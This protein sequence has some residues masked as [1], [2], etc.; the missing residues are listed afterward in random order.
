MSILMSQLK[1]SLLLF[2]AACFV[3]CA[4][5]NEPDPQGYERVLLPL[6]VGNELTGAFG[7]R[8]S[9]ELAIRNEADV[10]VQVFQAECSYFC[11]CEIITE[12]TPP[13]PIPPHAP[14]SAGGVGVFT[15]IAPHDGALIYVQRRYADDVSLNLRLRE[16]SRN[17]LS[18]GAEVPIVREDRLLSSTAHLLNIPLDNPSRIR[19]RVYG[20][21]SPSGA[22]DVRVRIFAGDEIVPSAEQVLTMSPYPAPRLALPQERPP[23]PSFG[24]ISEIRSLI[25]GVS[26][27]RIRIDVEP[28][29]P[30]LVFWPLVTI[31]NNV[32]QEVT[33]VTPQ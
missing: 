32:S 21:S 3:P 16:L 24:Q 11:T 30:G 2:L 20:I 14:A 18:A 29:T 10:P 5:A 25:P 6:Y 26:A 7:S 9:T 12:C 8:W 13:Q 33:L 27:A 19:L 17:E 4:W 23:V 31:T 1:R 28:V 22:G 15:D